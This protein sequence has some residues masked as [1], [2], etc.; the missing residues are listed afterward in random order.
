MT[1]AIAEVLGAL[2]DDVDRLNAVSANVANIQT[3]GYKRTLPQ[4]GASSFSSALV[5]AG[6][7]SAR[8]PNEPAVDVT[9]GAVTSTRNMLDVS[10]NGPGFLELQQD[11]Q[12]FYT[13]RGA[14]EIDASGQL[15]GAVG[16][17]VQGVSGP[18]TVTSRKV[19]ISANGTVLDD[20]R[21]VGQLKIVDVA[22][23]QLTPVGSA[24]YRLAAGAAATEDRT[25]R[26]QQGFLENSNVDSAT[27]MVS[28]MEIMRHAEG[29][30]KVAQGYDEMLGSAIE[31]LGGQ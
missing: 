28:M 25:T 20:G 4:S 29:L 30:Q 26:I 5:R 31:K 27:E 17:P 23:A 8:L 9:A 10:L 11:G 7:V 13:R 12:P 24:M 21:S 2:R 16:L 1:D 14:L 18:I 6:G 22:A 19:T 15:V 3:P